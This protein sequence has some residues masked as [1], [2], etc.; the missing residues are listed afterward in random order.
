MDLLT[1]RSW[2]AR[3]TAFGFIVVILFGNF[4]LAELLLGQSLASWAT[5][6]MWSG[7]L[8]VFGGGL[9]L[10][11]SHACRRWHG[12]DVDTHASVDE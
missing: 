3:L 7:I 12:P 9:G 11:V 4:L 2:P 10:L 5:A 1:R 6:G 8:I